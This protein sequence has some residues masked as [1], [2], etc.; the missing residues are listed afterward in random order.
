MPLRRRR[1]LVRPVPGRAGPG[2]GQSGPASGRGRPGP[3]VALVHDARPERPGVDEVEVDRLRDRGQFRN[4]RTS[5]SSPSPIACAARSAPPTDTSRSV[6]AS[7]AATSSARGAVASR[8]FPSTRSSVRLNTTFGS[9][10]HTSANAS[11]SAVLRISG[12]VSQG[13]ITSYSRRP[14]R[15]APSSP[16]C[17][18]LNRNCSSPGALQPKPPA[19]S[20]TYPSRVTLI[21]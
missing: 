19:R 12:S 16:T 18:R 5:S 17:A 10:A 11:P 6:A 8:A 14:H 1:A 15:Y 9:A 2:A 4:A 13:S 20:V 7:A 21:E 3:A